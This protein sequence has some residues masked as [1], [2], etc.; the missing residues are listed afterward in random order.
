MN[1]DD[2]K[3]IWSPNDFRDVVIALRASGAE[4]LGVTAPVI[5]IRTRE[6]LA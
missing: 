2:L 1:L 3:P 4:D 6:R 5:D